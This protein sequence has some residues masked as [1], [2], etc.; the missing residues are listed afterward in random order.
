MKTYRILF[1]FCALIITLLLIDLLSGIWYWNRLNLIFDAAIF[2]NLLTPIMTVLAT[3]IYGWALFTTINQNKIILSQNIK[4]Y[5]EKEIAKY[6]LKTKENKIDEK[7]IFDGEDINCLNYVKYIAKTYYIL[8]ENEEFN[9]DYIQCEK[10][11]VITREYIKNRSYFKELLFLYNFSFGINPV[12]FLYSDI[13]T[14]IIEINGSKLIEEDKNILKKEIYRNLVLEYVKFFE[15]D[16]DSVLSFPKI[17]F[18]YQDF[19]SD[20]VIWKRLSET[21]FNNHYNFFKKELE[22]KAT[23]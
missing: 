7:F 13:K 14:L 22:N 18:I 2:N 21:S 19:N 10:G 1:I 5:Y 4:P 9:V 15:M 8:M 6:V 17:P 20:T 11:K 16:T 12:E 3:I 23:N